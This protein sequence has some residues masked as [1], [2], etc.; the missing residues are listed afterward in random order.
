MTGEPP[1]PPQV[2]RY[3][4][5]KPLGRGGMGVVHVAYDPDLDRKVAL[6]LLRR[7]EGAD[8]ETARARL[9]RE[10]QAMARISHPNVIPIFDAGVWGAQVFLA[11]ELVEGDTLQTWI[12]AQPRPWREVV[13]AFLA[14]GEGLAAAHAAGLVHRDFKPSNVLVA[15][16]GRIRVTD[17]GIARQLG[18]PD[19][20]EETT[21]PAGPDHRMLGK[22]ITA[23]DRVLGT[24]YFMSPEQLR[25]AVVDARSDQFSFCVSL[26]WALY[27]DRPYRDLDLGLPMA[28]PSAGATAPLSPPPPRALAPP[29]DGAVPAWVR[30]ALARGLSLDPT[31]RF[32]SMRELLQAL[33]QERRRARTRKVAAAVLGVAAVAALSAGAAYRRA[34]ACAEAGQATAEVWGPQAH[35]KLQASLAGAGPA[36]GTDAARR[37]SGAL[38]RYAAAWARQRVEVCQAAQQ[39][40]QAEPLLSRRTACLERRRKD[41]EAVVALLSGADAKLAEKAVDAASA[42]PSL[43]ECADLEALLEQQGLPEDPARRAEIDRLGASL[44]RLKAVL[45]AGGVK[46]ALAAAEAARPAVEATGHPPLLAEWRFLQAT[47]EDQ[48]GNSDAAAGGLISAM[49]DAEAGR[50]DRLKITILAKLVLVDGKR[51][52]FDRADDWGGLAEAALRRIGGDAELEADLRVSQGVTEITRGRLDAAQARLERAQQLQHGLPPD[53]PKRARMTFLL[54]NLAWQ[55]GDRE[56]AAELLAAA[57]EQTRAAV[58]PMHPDMARRHGLLSVV[59]RELGHAATAL[60]HAQAAVDVRRSTLGQNSEQTAEAM[61]ELGM[62]LLE[63]RRWGEALDVYRGALAIKQKALPAGDEQLQYSYDGV[64]QALLGLGKGGEAVEPLRRAVA[65][66]AAPPGVLAESG[67]ALARALHEAGRT[68]EAAAEAARAQARFTQAGQAARAAEV[69]AW[70]AGLQRH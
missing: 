61:D 53:H 20:R 23:T 39:G 43:Q 15:R 1:P 17:F 10:A 28:T 35:E 24:P 55:R 64:G 33:S 32:P 26:Y 56:R 68:A 54:G 13:E 11:M 21:I 65:I 58:G 38:D 47:A 44:A 69:T 5:L 12:E 14:A 30:Q 57:L 70:R 46:A 49:A 6:K 63:L 34:R 60:P 25:G 9:L 19:P 42:L 36:F 3:V 50:A 37:A 59:L 62:C 51:G 41:L 52:R 40:T 31:G 8:E 4:L 7:K 29:R 16:D 45:D 67:F 22:T 2:G 66:T 18:E 27:R 48:V